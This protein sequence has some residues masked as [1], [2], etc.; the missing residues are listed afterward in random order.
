MPYIRNGDVSLALESR[1]NGATHLLFA[2]GWISSR[3]MWF[4]VASR[5]DPAR[6]TLHLLDFR[7]AGLSDRPSGGHDL[8]GYASDLRAALVAIDA[9]LTLVA[10]SMGGK[11]AQYVALTPPANLT[12]LVLVAPGSARAM[13]LDERHRAIAERAFGSRERIA[14]FQRGAMVRPIPE[15]S[16]ER[17]ISD[18][19]VAQREA[20]F[21]WY[22]HGRTSDFAD[23]LGEIAL[24]TIV[25]GADKD[26]LVP[27]AR[28][29]R[30]V[31]DP[32]DGALAVMLRGVGHNIPVE[33]PDEV[34]QLIG[35]FCEG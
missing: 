23:R 29:R 15:E 5:L 13:P 35:R 33:A 27:P 32:I 25:L 18:A 31:V 22:D 19:L 11:I 21:H 12:R 3:R 28:L 4:D 9:P 24:P 6:F 14:R 17:I 7:G 8:E 2:H 16:F 20:W 34:V 10:H 30:N 26:P 1:G